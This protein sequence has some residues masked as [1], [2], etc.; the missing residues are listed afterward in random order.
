MIEIETK[1]ISSKNVNNIVKK[2]IIKQI[3]EKNLENIEIAE[4]GAG[5]GALAISIQKYLCDN[6]I[7]YNYDCFDIEPEQINNQKINIKCNYLD[8]QDLFNIT[9][10]YDIIIAVEIIEHIENPFHFIREISKIIKINGVLIITT[11]NILSLSSRFRYF[12][13]GCYDYFRRPYNEYWLNMGHLNPI[14]PIQLVY[15]LRKNRN[16][17]SNRY[18][19]FNYFLIIFLPFIFF[20]SWFHFINREKNIYQKKRNKELLKIIFNKNIL[21]GKIGIYEIIKEKERIGSKENWHKSDNE[22]L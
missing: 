17:Y 7:K 15:I 16:V 20:Y 14:N 18:I 13:S 2:I 6:S 19:L 3:I 5:K 8:V 9:K 21:F 11:P 1:S 12:F 22:F 4:I 10:K